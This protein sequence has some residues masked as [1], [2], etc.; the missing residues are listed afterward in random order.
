M[1]GE[2]AVG[3]P[4]PAPKVRQISPFLLLHHLGPLIIAPGVNPMDIGPHPHRGFA[5]V[6]FVY[7]GEVAHSDS[8]GNTRTVTGGGVQWMSAGSGIVHS[9][10]VGKE[11][12]EAGGPFE[13]IQLWINLPRHLKMSEPSYQP[14][15]ADDIPCFQD[16]TGK[17]RLNVIAGQYNGLQGPVN[18]PTPVEAFTIHLEPGGSLTIPTNQD[19][20]VLLYQLAG[21][22]EI[23]SGRLQGRQL[24][25]FNF[26]GEAIKLMARE[27]GRYLYLSA[28]P[29][30]EPLAQ[31]GP[32]VMNRPEELQQ[33]IRDYQDGKMGEL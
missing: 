32:F 13:M 29:I 1:M 15:D 26:E 17:T 20:N 9:E 2:V 31:Y 12:I 3:Q 22:T 21:N 19:W 18:H 11:L 28:P 10:S 8:L 25:V 33:A 24:A 23:G 5:P 7:Q 30:N 6:S 4:L 16:Q 14:F 27:P